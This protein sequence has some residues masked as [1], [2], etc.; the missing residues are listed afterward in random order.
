[1]DSPAVSL[2]FDGAYIDHWRRTRGLFAAYQARA[3]FFVT[4]PDALSSDDIL[5]LQALAEDGHEVGL[6]GAADKPFERYLEQKT[7]RDY[8]KEEIAPQVQTLQDH[9]FNVRCFAFPAHTEDPRMVSPL[10]SRFRVVRRF[11]PTAR[12]AGRVY[13][14]SNQNVV[15]CIGSLNM[16][17]DPALDEEYYEKCL[18]QTRNRNGMS[19]FCGQAICSA[20]KADGAS[21]MRPEDLEWFL[22]TLRQ[23]KLP[24]LPLSTL[25]R[26]L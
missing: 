8:L 15:D 22:W 25:A 16:A 19:V 21:F 2:T 17:S 11:G 14:T 20:D 18:R 10:L 23:K 7:P 24:V 4:A 9:G 6:Q 26:A 3:T 1:M 12:P 5:A 13:Q